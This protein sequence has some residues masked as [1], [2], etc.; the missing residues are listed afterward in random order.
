MFFFGV[1]RLEHRVSHP[2]AGVALVGPC[3]VSDRLGASGVEVSVSMLTLRVYLFLG[4]AH[5]R[6]RSWV[7]RTNVPEVM[8]RVMTV[9]H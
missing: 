3:H 4:L 7:A 9:T 1:R 6:C 5:R 2:T 8:F